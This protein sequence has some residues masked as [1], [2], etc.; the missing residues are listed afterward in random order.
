MLCREF[1]IEGARPGAPRLVTLYLPPNAYLSGR[2]PIVFCTDGQMVPPFAT[3]VERDIRDGELPA[4]VLVGVHSSRHRSQEYNLGQDDSK[5]R[6]HEQFFTEEL[7]AWL[8]AEFG[9]AADRNQTAVF[10]CSHG[11]AFAL[12]MAS[13]HRDQYGLVIAFSVA[14]TFETLE[15]L[16]SNP[17]PLPRFYL[18]AGTREKP[19]LKTTR[20][21]ARHLKRYQIDHVVTER[22]AGHDYGYWE[23]ELPLALKWGFAASHSGEACD[24]LD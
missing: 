16:Q 9:L 21:L 2:C 5:F 6:W 4:I 20:R 23:T 22:H 14:G 8:H 11:G 15:E 19:L 12:T 17:Q 3:R 18:S 1:R 13:R 10:G 7:P 24:N